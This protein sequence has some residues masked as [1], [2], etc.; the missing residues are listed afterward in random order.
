M[1]R[2]TNMT[3]NWPIILSAVIFFFGG[4]YLIIFVENERQ[5]IIKYAKAGTTPKSRIYQNFQKILAFILPKDCVFLQNNI[6]PFWLRLV[7]IIL[8]LVSLLIVYGMI[9]G[10]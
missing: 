2:T 4:L 8:I 9:N 1:I 3:K 10:W 6:S 5:R 7:G